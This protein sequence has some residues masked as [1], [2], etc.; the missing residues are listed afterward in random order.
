MGEEEKNE[1]E[2]GTDSAQ[3]Q[4]AQMSTATTMEQPPPLA[5]Y[6]HRQVLYFAG[7]VLPPTTSAAGTGS[8]PIAPDHVIGGYE[9]ATYCPRL[10]AARYKYSTYNHWVRSIPQWQHGPL[11]AITS[12][13]DS[14]AAAS[15]HEF[16]KH[17]YCAHGDSTNTDS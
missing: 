16:H 15:T 17:D 10:R 3:H 2:K 6:Y 11:I 1:E 9:L 5:R 13:L 7:K 14:A 12:R 8:Q 4:L